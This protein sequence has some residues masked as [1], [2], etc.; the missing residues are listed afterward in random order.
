MELLN[1]VNAKAA[2]LRRLE[3]LNPNLD[4]QEDP[5]VEVARIKALVK[6]LSSKVLQHH[7]ILE[8]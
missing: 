3:R 5:D 6:R 8:L 7:F 2:L 1:L 4:I